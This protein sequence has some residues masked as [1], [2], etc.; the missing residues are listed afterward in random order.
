MGEIPDRVLA[1]VAGILVGVPVAAGFLVLSV[2]LVAGRAL[3]RS[4][5][6]TRGS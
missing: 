1:L 6:I 5:A 4:V 2:G 3:M